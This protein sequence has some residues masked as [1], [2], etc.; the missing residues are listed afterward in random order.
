VL[1]LAAL[2]ASAFFGKQVRFL[3]SAI[4]SSRFMAEGL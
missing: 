2:C 3:S 4:F 1:A